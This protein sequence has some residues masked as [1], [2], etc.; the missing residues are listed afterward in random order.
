MSAVEWLLWTSIGAV[1]Y[2]YA[3]Y[4]LLLWVAGRLWGRPPVAPAEPY[5]PGVTMIVP[6]HNERPNLEAKLANTRAIDYPPGK[7]EVLF[8]SDGSTDGTPEY[9]HSQADGLIKVFELPGRGGKAAALNFGL[10]RASHPIILFSDATIAFEP[11]AIRC[12][13]Q[14]F[15]DPVVGCVS[16]EDRI[17]GG[18]G[19]GLYGRYELFLRRQESALSSIVGASGSFYSQRRELCAPFVPFVAPDFYSVLH[20]VEQGHRAVTEPT[21]VGHMAA[22]ADPGAEFQ[23]KVRTL[24]RGITTFWRYVHLLNP[25]K[26]RL[27]AFQLLSHKLMR[28]L[29]PFFL[30]V[31][32]LANAVLVPV[33][34][35]YA[36]LF[37]LQVLFYALACVGFW[38]RIPLASSLPVRIALYFTSANYAT[39]VAWM[40]FFRGG[41]QEIWSPS[42]R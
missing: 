17:A 38:A 2:A 6:V 3:G 5:L 19:E 13:V 40:R 21:A 32:L 41:R 33:S 18:G 7:L 8:V 24:L 25:V 16:G 20:V 23:R 15:A 29:A 36:A 1:A 9:L 35:F 28:W 12:L 37:A 34:P 11:T 27:F 14:P 39:L 4:P 30:L 22:V 42:R 26:Y 10:E 31:A